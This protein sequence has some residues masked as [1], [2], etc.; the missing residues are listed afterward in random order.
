MARNEKSAEY[1][2]MDFTGRLADFLQNNRRRIIIT[3]SLIIG[4]FIIGIAG[5]VVWERITSANIRTAEEFYEQY[6]DMGFERPGA[7]D[8]EKTAEYIKALREFAEKKSGY[9]AVRVWTLLGRVYQTR[10]EWVLAEEAWSR[11]AAVKPASYITPVSLFNAAAAA[12]EQGDIARAIELLRKVD[13][14]YADSF[15][16]IARN[17][18]S[19]GRL[20]EKQQDTEEA[21]SAYRRLVENWPSSSWANLANGRII[22]LSINR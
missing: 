12:E 4:V 22:A 9:A 7:V 1:E 13:T 14:E 18:F 16:G 6:F 15:P 17:V 8:E 20:Y 2:T 21:I 11:A 10:K 5:Y 3:G 19:L